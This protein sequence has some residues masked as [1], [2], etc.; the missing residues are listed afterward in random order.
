MSPRKDWGEEVHPP[1]LNETIT[2]TAN[3]DGPVAIHI[4][5]VYGDVGDIRE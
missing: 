4:V 5:A 1:L 3:P 2:E